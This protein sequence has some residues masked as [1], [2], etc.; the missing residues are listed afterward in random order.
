MIFLVTIRSF[1]EYSR[2]VHLALGVGDDNADW[3]CQEVIL[4][5]LILILLLVNS[6]LTP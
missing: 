6:W 1:I 5:S 3:L 4:F 2:R